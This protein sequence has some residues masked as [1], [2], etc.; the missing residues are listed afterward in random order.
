[1][2]CVLYQ[3]ISCISLFFEVSFSSYYIYNYLYINNIYSIIKKNRPH[4]LKLIH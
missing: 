2:N 3:C 1:M 4:F